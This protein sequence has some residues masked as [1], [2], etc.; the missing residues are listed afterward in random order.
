MNNM[1]MLINRFMQ[2]SGSGSYNHLTPKQKAEYIKIKK[3]IELKK[4]SFFHQSEIPNRNKNLILT[5]Y[6]YNSINK[7]D[8]PDKFLISHQRGNFQ[9]VD[10]NY[11]SSEKILV[12]WYIKEIGREF[13]VGEYYGKKFY[14]DFSGV[15]KSVIATEQTP[16]RAR[17]MPGHAIYFEINKGFIQKWS[18]CYDVTEAD[19]PEYQQILTVVKNEINFDGAISIHTFSR[20]LDWKSP[21]IKGIIDSNKLDVYVDVISN[22]INTCDIMHSISMLDELRGI[23]LPTASTI[24]HFV[25]PHE[26]PII[27]VRTIEALQYYGYIDKKISQEYYKQHIENYKEF[28]TIMHGIKQNL[29]DFNLREI[30]RALSAFHKQHLN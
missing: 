20:I 24:M 13:V 23:G 12:R 15:N 5:D 6:C 7:G 22:A 18:M 30:D 29:E 11:N 4:N 26:V 28:Y 9:F 25:R 14:W 1:Q 10:F 8:F 2:R 27:D 16:I 3:Y 19:E 17:T 21:R